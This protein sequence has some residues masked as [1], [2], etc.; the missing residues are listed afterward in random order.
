[1][2]VAI[3]YAA[4]LCVPWLGLYATEKLLDWYTTAPPLRRRGRPDD[5]ALAQLVD[6]LRRLDDEYRRVEASDLP[7][8][9]ARLRSLALAYDEVLRRCCRALDLPEPET[10][11]L[12]ALDRL[13]TEAALAQ[14]GVLW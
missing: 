1:M 6:D 3:A 12:G 7:A 10:V 2:S 14:R 9:A 5:R 8:R 4:L 11:P 13:Q